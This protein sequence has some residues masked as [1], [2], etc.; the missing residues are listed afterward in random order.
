EL[1]N[2]GAVL[3][4]RGDVRVVNIGGRAHGDEHFLAVG[5]K[6]NVTCGVPT[7]CRQVCN[8]LRRTTRLYIAILIGEAHYRVGVADIDPLRFRARRVEVDAERL[9]QAAGEH[10]HL[11]GLALAGDPA[12]YPDVAGFGLGHENFAVGRGANDPRIIEPARVLLYFEAG[13]DL[14]PRTLWTR[15]HLGAI[16]G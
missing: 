1:Q 16:A 4:C 10:R 12:E 14:R 13:R 5:R 3:F 2:I 15:H 9:V 8:V 7:A 11:L 6:L